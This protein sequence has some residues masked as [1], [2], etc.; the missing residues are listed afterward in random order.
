M[1]PKNPDYVT[2]TNRILFECPFITDLGLD[3]VSLEPGRCET[4]LII[5]PK[6]LQQ[7]GFVHAGVQATVADHTAGAAGASL[8]AADELVLSAEFKINLLRA[9]KGQKLKCIATVL[10]PG[11]QLTIVESELYCENSQGSKLVS[12]TTVTLAILK[13]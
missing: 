2:E 6:H 1:T 5:Q 4:E 7:D 9:A 13:K 3:V 8:I 10:K 12:K 11:N